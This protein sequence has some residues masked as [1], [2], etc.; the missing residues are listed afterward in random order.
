MEC[1]LIEHNELLCSN[2][3]ETYLQDYVKF[4]LYVQDSC[5]V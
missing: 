3:L 1:K 2:T 4:T 5:D